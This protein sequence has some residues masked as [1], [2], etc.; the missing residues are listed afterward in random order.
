MA[1]DRAEFERRVRELVQQARSADKAATAAARAALDRAHLELIRQI[2][3]LPADASSYSRFQL[4]DLK[5]ATERAMEEFDRQ[6]TGELKTAQADGFAQGKETVD[7][8]LTDSIG[9]PAS[10][11]DLSQ[12][13]LIVAQGYSADLVKGLSEAGRARL[14][15]TLSRAFLGGQS[16][17]EIMRQIGRSIGQGEFGVISRR[18]ETIYRTEVLRI[19][20][21]ATQARLKQANDRGVPAKKMW[22]HAGAP[23]KPRVWHLAV[24][25]QVKPVDEPFEIPGGGPGGAS[26]E[27]MFPRDP[28]AS[29][30]NTVNC[31]CQVFPWLDSFEKFAGLTAPA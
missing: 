8:T 15:A 27:L 19:Q 12:A 26:E 3:Q 17:T 4:Q 1:I 29:A 21:I 18:A 7:R 25:R 11:A 31:G 14:N 13:Q 2:A 5:R 23:F 9:T 28:A 6:L 10:L 20:S 30:E 22:V 24:N 16:V